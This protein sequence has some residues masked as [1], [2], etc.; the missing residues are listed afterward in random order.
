M[1]TKD[2]AALGLVRDG[3]RDSLYEIANVQ[4]RGE[5][6]IARSLALEWGFAV[7]V[8]R[9]TLYRRLSL[10]PLPA[11][12]SGKKTISQ[13]P[14]VRAWARRQ[15][16][17]RPQLVEPA[18]E[19]A[20][21]EESGDRLATLR[22]A[23]AD[24]KCESFVYFIQPVDGGLIKIGVARNVKKR[25]AAHQIGSPVILRLLLAIPGDASLESIMHSRFGRLRRHGEWFEP[26]PLLLQFI[27]EKRR[28]T[29]RLQ[30]N[31]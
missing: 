15:V 14:D 10:D 19:W 18:R 20:K 16:H 1:S 9:I 5:D 26:A 27:E 22:D 12:G 30:A 28:E 23:V 4:V 6:P 31:R 7:H 24:V 13:V 21:K 29:E 25:L 8:T 2:N 11:T 17:Y 3:R